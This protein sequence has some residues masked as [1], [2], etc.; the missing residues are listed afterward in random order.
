M[1]VKKNIK[2]GLNKEDTIM[3]AT[4][5]KIPMIAVSI[6]KKECKYKVNSYYPTTDGYSKWNV[7]SNEQKNNARNEM[8]ISGVKTFFFSDKEE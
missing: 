1:L 5:I 7:L 2:R 4:I 6:L 8:L 3:Q